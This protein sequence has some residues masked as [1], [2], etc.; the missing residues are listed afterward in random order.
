MNGAGGVPMVS[1]VVPAPTGWKL[2]E[3]EELCGPKTTGLVTM[4]PTAVL[5][6]VTGT[7]TEAIRD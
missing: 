4:V 5:E 7:L 3:A 2:V 6:L 1:V